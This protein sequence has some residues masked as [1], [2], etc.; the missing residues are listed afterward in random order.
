MDAPIDEYLPEYGLDPRITVRMLLQHISGLFDY[1]GQPNPDGTI[2]PGIPVNGKDF[3]D[4]RF[5]TY[6]PTELVAVSLA[7]PLNFE[8]GTNLS[9]SNTN[10]ILAAQLIERLTHTPYAVQVR[11]RILRPLRLRDTVFPGASPAI[12]GPHAYGYLNYTDG[13]QLRTSD[14]AHINPTWGWAAGEIIS[15]PHDLDRV[16][17]RPARRRPPPARPP[18]A[19]ARHPT[20]WRRSRPTVDEPRPVLRWGV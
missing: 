4:N 8:S 16:H 6:Q 9:Y 11:Q 15:T 14:V 17:H 20:N 13:E 10:Y 18:R 19:D 2:T 12:S 5:H 1:T 3:V 7:K